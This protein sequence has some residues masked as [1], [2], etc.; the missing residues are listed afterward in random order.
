MPRKIEDGVTVS[1]KIERNV[2]AGVQ[3]LAQK[4]DRSA[5]DFMRTVIK[6]QV[7]WAVEKGVITDGPFI[8]DGL[9]PEQCPNCERVVALDP[10]SGLCEKCSTEGTEE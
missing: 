4:D 6:K 1:F 5:R 10:D 8:S 7:Q 2:F 3:K 9:K